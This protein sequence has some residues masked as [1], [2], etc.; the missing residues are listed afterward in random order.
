MA[1]PVKPFFAMEEQAKEDVET[2]LDKELEKTPAAAEK[3][4]QLEATQCKE[5][6][7]LEEFKWEIPAKAEEGGLSGPPL[8][9]ETFRDEALAILSEDL[10]KWNGPAQYLQKKFETAE[11]R[12][13]FKDALNL[14]FPQ[15]PELIYHGSSILPGSL[16]TEM[17]LQLSDLGFT[18]N[19]STKPPPFL[20]TC[21]LLLDE[22]LTNTVQT[23]REPLLLS[24]GGGKEAS[25]WACY[26]KGSARSCTMLYLA[27]QVI[28]RRWQL[29]V[30][31]PDLL[32]SM[33]AVYAKRGI[34]TSD[35]QSIA[36]QNAK[37]SQQGSIRRAHC[38]L[39]W[40]GKLMILQGQG[41]NPEQVLKAWN[42]AATQA[43][44]ISGSKRVAVLQLLKMPKEC[45]QTLLSHLS[46]FGSNTAFMEDCFSNKKLQ[47]GAKARSGN[48]VWN[49]RLT[50]TSEGLLMMLQYVHSVHTQKLPGTQKKWSKESVEEAM[51]M[52]QLLWSLAAELVAENPIPVAVVQEKVRYFYF[53]GGMAIN[54][55]KVS[56]AMS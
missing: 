32:H 26:V 22:F 8:Q 9:P 17:I 16:D 48:K 41:L 39:T 14:A 36:L 12:D 13:K 30:L 24:Q 33:T 35:S 55:S 34:L 11:E 29:S 37:L 49:D 19:T 46:M 2:L 27:A 45:C 18:E 40:L 38:V 15:R 1:C 43:G 7:K 53:S 20:R 52:A 54:D 31:H 5:Q 3:S 23:Q 25:F 44:Q 47:I 21:L 28:Q 42:S 50:V 6:A 4:S 51:N 10:R 56:I